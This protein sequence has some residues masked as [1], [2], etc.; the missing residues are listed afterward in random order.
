VEKV[1]D[2]TVTKC[3]DNKLPFSHRQRNY[4]KKNVGYMEFISKSIRLIKHECRVAFVQ[5][6]WNCDVILN[7]P[8]FD[9]SIDD[10][11]NFFSF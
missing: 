5:E 2:W 3:M 7:A 1:K 8:N 6:Q 11:K 4:C 9:R 10:R